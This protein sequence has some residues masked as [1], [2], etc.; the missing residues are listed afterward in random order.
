[1]AKGEES[2]RKVKH[3]DVDYHSIRERVKLGQTTLIWVKSTNNPADIL[4]KSIS[5]DDYI[6]HRTEIGLD[7][8]NYSDDENEEEEVVAELDTPADDDEPET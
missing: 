3:I 1:M 5:A 6:R 4:T 8:E 7:P 2:H